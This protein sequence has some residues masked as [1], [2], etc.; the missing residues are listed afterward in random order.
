M[1]SKLQYASSHAAND[2]T[3]KHVIADTGVIADAKRH[4]RTK[5]AFKLQDLHIT[6]KVTSSED[7]E[8]K[9]NALMAPCRKG[10]QR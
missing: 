6:G 4:T 10:E 5:C 3:V 7:G 8:T 1:S 9:M 2:V